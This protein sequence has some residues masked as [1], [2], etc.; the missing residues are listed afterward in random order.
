MIECTVLYVEGFVFSLIATPSEKWLKMEKTITIHRAIKGYTKIENSLIRDVSLSPQARFVLI[1]LIS[2]PDNFKITVKGLITLISG[3]DN[4]AYHGFGRDGIYTILS[5]LEK[6]GYIEKKMIRGEDGRFVKVTY[7]FYE[8]KKGQDVSQ[9]EE[10]AKGVIEEEL[11]ST[12]YDELS[13]RLSEQ[14]SFL[15][16]LVEEKNIAINTENNE[17]IE[18][19]DC[20]IVKNSAINNSTNRSSAEVCTKENH[21]CCSI[22]TLVTQENTD[23]LIEGSEV[24]VIDVEKDPTDKFGWQ[25]LT[26]MTINRNKLNDYDGKPVKVAYMKLRNAGF[27]AKHIIMCWRWKQMECDD[28]KYAPQLL[29]WLE[30]DAESALRQSMGKPF[31]GNWKINA[32]YKSQLQELGYQVA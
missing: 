21:N 29:K 30:N 3:K 22:P 31:F 23:S 10:Q 15:T 24:A 6:E 32:N 14:H 7:H 13:K 19:N 20:E 11:E 17:H 4:Q 2:L 28:P 27:S 18:D 9:N 16:K 8:N 5:E 25:I 1:L 26:Q 12:E